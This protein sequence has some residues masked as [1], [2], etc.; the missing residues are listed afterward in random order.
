MTTPMVLL[1]T[2]PEAFLNKG[3]GEYELLD[4]AHNLRKLGIVADTYSPYSK[5]LVNYDIVIHFSINSSGLPMLEAAK[6]AGKK[7]IL[8]PNFWVNKAKATSNAIAKN[9][10]DMA[11]VVVFKSNTERINFKN[12]AP[13]PPEKS[14]MIPTP[15]DV[16]FA[17]PT[18][19]RLFRKSF[20]LEKYLLWIGIFEPRKNQLAVIT[21]L[22]DL[23]IPMVFVGNYRDKKYFDACKK[24]AP[25]HFIFLD[26]MEQASDILRAA[27]RESRLYIE[28]TL[29][30]AGKSVLEA[31][32]SG[33]QVLVSDQPWEHEHLG[34]FAT[35]VNPKDPESIRNGVFNALRKPINQD[36]ASALAQKHLMPQA[37]DIL[38]ACITELK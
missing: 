8:W 14:L 25:E 6:K 20:N 27:M 18:P 37:L 3:G 1:T 21:A 30:P 29:E 33:A 5:D 26:P 17:S 32:I 11:D 36:Q 22:E 7:I 34:K 9:I 13:V 10:V 31:A 19:E 2:Y 4:I 16:I 15:I 35:Y 23:D 28:P 24:A 12:I 38:V